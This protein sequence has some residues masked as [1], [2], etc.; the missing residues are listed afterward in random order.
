MKKIIVLNLGSTSF[1]FKLYEMGAE[2]ILLASGGVESIGAAGKY[3]ISANGREEKAACACKTHMDA[4]SLCLKRL[5]ALG[6]SVDLKSLD[7]VGYKAVHGGRF[8]GAQFVTRELLAEMERMA[9]LT[10]A[11]N[12]VYIAMMRAVAQKYPLLPQIACFETGFHAMMPKERRYYGVPLEW[13]E[14]YGVRRWGFHGN[15]HSY[16]AWKMG[17]EAPDCRRIVSAHLGGSSSVCAI[18]DGHSV[19]SSMGATPQ[20]GVFNNNRVGDFDAFCLPVLATQLGG[21]DNV[22]K[23]LSKESGFQGLSGVSN[24]MR[25]VELAAACGNERA[26]LALDA[27]ADSVVGYIGMQTA[28]MGGLDALVFT[29]GIGLKGSEFRENVVSRLGFVHAKLDAQKNADRRI[30]GLISAPDSGIKIYVFE[31]NE[32]LMVARGCVQCLAKN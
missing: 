16:I 20:S 28:F 1:K 27:F 2:E 15:S 30:Q 22:M 21:L 6:L 23:L 19:A 4:M 8:S 31:T 7:A 13:A 17:M 25:E 18:L 9:P 11:H 5:S 24:D 3:E 10:P 12:P 14:K 29:G 32:E 26:Q